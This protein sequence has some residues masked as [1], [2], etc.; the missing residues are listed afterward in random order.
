MLEQALPG[1]M[2]AQQWAVA[3]R[4]TPRLWG[5]HRMA[6]SR[7]AMLMAGAS[8]LGTPL[9]AADPPPKDDK[10]DKGEIVV[11]GVRGSAETDVKALISYD[12]RDIEAMGVTS[13]GDLLRI[14]GPS[15]KSADGKD[16]IYL[17]NAQR[18]SGFEEI[19]TLPP[20]AILKVEVMPEQAALKFGYPPT[21]RLMNFITKP[22]FR[23]LDVSANAGATTEGGSHTYGGNTTLTRI[24][25]GRRLTLGGEY[26]HTDP[27][28]QSQRPIVPDPTNP[29]DATGNVIGIGGN[30]L[31]PALSAVAGHVVTEASVPTDP[32]TRG[33]VAAYLAGAD[34]LRSFDLGPYRTLV[35]REDDFK[36]NAVL[37]TAVTDTIS[38]SFTGTAE[39]KINRSL[40]GLPSVALTLPPGSPYSPFAND[41]LL[42][43]YLTDQP[44]LVQHMV[45]TTLHGGALLRGNF[46]SWHWDA[47]TTLDSNDVRSHGDRGI[48][49][50]AANAAVA[51]GADPFGPLSLPRLTQEAHTLTRKGEFKGVANGVAIVIPSGELRATATVEAERSTVDSQSRGFTDVDISLGRTRVEGGLSVDI[52]LASRDFDFLPFLNKLSASLSVNVRDISDAGTLSD[53]S[54]GVN[55]QPITGVQLSATVKNVA[56][57]PDMAQKSAPTQQ[58]T[59]IPYF[60]YRTGQTAFVTT[61]SGGNPDLRAQQAHYTVLGLNLK[62]FTARQLT[63]TVNY[64]WGTARHVSS[65]ISEFP[66]T[67]AAFPDRFL[68]DATGRLTTVFQTPTDLYRGE[69]K[70]I[71]TQFNWSGPLLKTPPNRD[72]KKPFSAGYFYSGAT[73]VFQFSNKI[74]LRP[75]LP[76]LDLLKGGTVDGSPHSRV[77]VWAWAGAGYKNDG[78]NLDWSYEGPARI[79]GGLAQTD[80]HFSGKFIINGTVHT[81]LH[82]RIKQPW[83]DKLTVSLQLQNIFGTRRHVEDATGATPNRYQPAFIDPLGRTMKLT[84]R[85]L[86]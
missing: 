61:I 16:P 77:Q 51:A 44:P 60:D 48:D 50:A 9:H 47:T 71:Q 11:R 74:E 85:K 33:D 79:D 7:I 40:Q 81:M 68:R 26:R 57:A 25:N 65:S 30:Q 58:S 62:P 64:Y 37:A 36:A 4:V 46:G 82:Q 6:A 49:P 21:Q 3:G 19:S 23:A 24:T 17:L 27:L 18:I 1:D 53:T 5:G 15:A 78:V 75:G 13:I 35:A 59:N 14:I 80:L 22:K 2:I 39:H 67:E 29:F 86:F 76:V 10:A 41:V 20:E 73:A 70:A 45:T 84:L 72:P 83:A 63:L 12:A 32:A 66:A 42:Y 43:R 54:Y 52:P 38:G 34:S 8:L 69:Q 55:W 31:D 28:L 56:T